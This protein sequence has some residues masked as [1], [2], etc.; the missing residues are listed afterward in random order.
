MKIA[1]RRF[2][3]SAMIGALIAIAPSASF[4]EDDEVSVG[5]KIY[6]VT[7]LRTLGTVKLFVGIIALIPASVLYTLRMPFDSDSGVYKEAAE[8]LVVEPANHVFR[9]PLG[10]DFDGG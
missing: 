10:E 3:I 8:I 1:L 7:I 5:A 2:L 9:R 4:A 6:D